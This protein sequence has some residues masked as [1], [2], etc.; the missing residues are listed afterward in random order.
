MNSIPL[1]LEWSTST[2]HDLLLA[3]CHDGTV[4]FLFILFLDLYYILFSIHWYLYTWIYFCCTFYNL[5]CIIICLEWTYVSVLGFHLWVYK[6]CVV[7]IVCK[8]LNL[9][10]EFH[11]TFKNLEGSDRA[12]F[13]YGG[14]DS[15]SWML[16]KQ[17]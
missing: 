5:N 9:L 11:R 12:Y 14:Y 6:Y 3:G 13:F 2:P 1:T 15:D 16:W 17:R 7:V 4:R 8:E 10:N